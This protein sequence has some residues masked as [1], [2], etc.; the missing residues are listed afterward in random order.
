MV[1]HTIDSIGLTRTGEG[2]HR[3]YGFR[4]HAKV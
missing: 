2:K 3:V 1:F 4:G